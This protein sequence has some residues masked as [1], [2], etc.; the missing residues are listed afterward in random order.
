MVEESVRLIVVTI[1]TVVALVPRRVTVF[2][3][4]QPSPSPSILAYLIAMDDELNYDS[5]HV[6]RLPKSSQTN[7]P[8]PKPFSLTQSMNQ[9]ENVV[10]KT[11]GSR[12]RLPFSENPKAFRPGRLLGG[13]QNANRAPIFPALQLFQKPQNKQLPPRSRAAT[14]F[15][16]LLPPSTTEPTSTPPNVFYSHSTPVHPVDSSPLKQEPP[17]TPFPFVS[18]NMTLT[19]NRQPTKMYHYR[20]LRNRE[21]RIQHSSKC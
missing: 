6:S 1:L 20:H 5:S 3:E 11:S 12:G 10:V 17:C 15:F 4:F 7:I 19:L 16:S 18:C 8:K 21:P 13:D 14:P 2:L 9:H